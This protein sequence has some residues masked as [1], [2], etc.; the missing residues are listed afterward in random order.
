MF[1]S[2]RTI[3]SSELTE[4]LYTNGNK[5]ATRHRGG[6]PEVAQPSTPHRDVGFDG[7]IHF[8]IFLFSGNFIVPMKSQHNSVSFVVPSDF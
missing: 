2:R 8:H 4:H 1:S 5:G 7:C 6:C 3:Y